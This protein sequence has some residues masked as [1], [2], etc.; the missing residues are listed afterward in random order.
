VVVRDAFLLIIRKPAPP[1]RFLMHIIKNLR[2]LKLGW[3][4]VQ[5]FEVKRR[6]GVQE[7]AEAEPSDTYVFLRLWL[8]D[9]EA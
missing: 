3:R 2:M 8:F 7:F 4:R 6:R 9:I 5:F 1:H